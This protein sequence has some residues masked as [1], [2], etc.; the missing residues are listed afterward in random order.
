MLSWDHGVSKVIFTPRIAESTINQSNKIVQYI[1]FPLLRSKIA[2]AFFNRKEVLSL[3]RTQRKVDAFAI[4][5]RKHILL[6]MLRWGR[7]VDPI[8]GVFYIRAPVMVK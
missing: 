6:K 5:K 2:A 7:A 8:S 4:R 3:L 1:V